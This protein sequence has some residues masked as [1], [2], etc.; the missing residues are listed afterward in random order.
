MPSNKEWT[1]SLNLPKFRGE[2][3]RIPGE[4]WQGYERGLDLAYRGTGAQGSFAPEV[5][6]AHLLLGLD[7]K[8]KVDGDLHPEWVEL[9][10][11]ELLITLRNYFNMAKWRGTKQQGLNDIVQKLDESCRA[12]AGR[13]QAAY[14]ADAPSAEY[15]PAT[16]KESKEVDEEDR[17]TTSEYDKEM[18]LYNRVADRLLL[19]YFL[20]GMRIDIRKPVIAAKPKLMSQA[21]EIAETHENYMESIGGMGSIHMNTGGTERTLNLQ[22]EPTVARASKQLMELNDRPHPSFRPRHPEGQESEQTGQANFRCFACN[23]PGHFQRECPERNSTEAQPF[24]CHFCG[25]TGHYQKDCNTKRRFLEQQKRKGVWKSDRPDIPQ[26]P[27]PVRRGMSAM[28]SSGHRPD[29][30]PPRRGREWDPAG[31]GMNVRNNNQGTDR[32]YRTRDT[33]QFSDPKNGQS[34]GQR[35]PAHQNNPQQ[36][37]RPRKQVNW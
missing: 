16:K 7:G 13:L 10:Y 35:A 26:A 25:R 14:R 11:E 23:K 30:P 9:P 29:T 19:R 8:A 2:P 37:F 20:R 6:K 34:R 21:L 15:I 33:S 22:V 17:L 4:T 24:E 28:R 18:A 12:F 32:R 1:G 3:D 36:S 27:P 5:K 31:K